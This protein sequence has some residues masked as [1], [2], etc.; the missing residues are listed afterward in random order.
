[1]RISCHKTRLS[2]GRGAATLTRVVI[3]SM[4]IAL[5]P[6][7]SV[8]MVVSQSHAK[9]VPHQSPV[10]PLVEDQEATHQGQCLFRLFC[11]KNLMPEEAALGLTGI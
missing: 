1:M 4:A 2:V 6:P 5:L 10:L 7:C 3:Y 11:L 8:F 9:F